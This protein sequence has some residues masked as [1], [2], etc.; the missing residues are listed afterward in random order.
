MIQFFLVLWLLPWHQ[1]P[2][3]QANLD[4]VRKIFYEVAAKKVSP[5]VLKIA[6]AQSLHDPIMRGY[7]GAATCMT[8]EDTDMPLAKLS[9]FNRGKQMLEE[10]IQNAPNNPDLI[11]LRYSIQRSAPSFLGYDSNLNKDRKFL[12]NALPGIEP[13]W[14]RI[15]IH[16]YLQS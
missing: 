3:S 8:A 1:K 12:L 10:A 5:A 9:R 4:E 16:N 14:F 2:E 11:F 7:H 13:E 15:F 6:T